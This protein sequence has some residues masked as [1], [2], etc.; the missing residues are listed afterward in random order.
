MLSYQ[1]PFTMREE[2]SQFDSVDDQGERHKPKSLSFLDLSPG[3]KERA[4]A[5]S[6]S[7]KKSLSFGQKHQEQ[8]R[9]AR[10]K[11]SKSS[12]A[13]L[14]D[15][16]EEFRHERRSRRSPNHGVSSRSSSEKL[17]DLQEEFRREQRSKRSPSYK[18]ASKSSTDT[19]PDLQEEFRQPRKPRRSPSHRVS[20]RLSPEPLPESQEVSRQ[21]RKAR[22]SSSNKSSPDLLEV[23]HRR[24]SASVECISSNAVV[25]EAM[26]Y[27][28]E[29]S[30]KLNSPTRSESYTA[31]ESR[32]GERTDRLSRSA[33]L[34]HEHRRPRRSGSKNFR[35]SPTP[36]EWHQ[37]LQQ[38]EDNA[39]L[40]RPGLRRSLKKSQ[41]PKERDSRKS[42]EQG[43]EEEYPRRSLGRKS[44][45]FRKR[46]PTPLESR[47]S[48]YKQEATPLVWHQQFQRSEDQQGERPR[49]RR[50]SKKSE[51][52]RME[53]ATK[54]P[55]TRENQTRDKQQEDQSHPERH[56]RSTSGK[57][58]KSSRTSRD[59]PTPEPRK[60]EDD[61]EDEYSVGR[62][63]SSKSRKGSR[64]SLSHEDEGDCPSSRR[65]LSKKSSRKK[66]PTPLESRK[67]SS[68]EDKEG[69]PSNR[70]SLSKKSSRK[71]S[72]T[73]LKSRRSLSQEDEDHRPRSRR[74]LSKK[75]SRT[76]SPTFFG[77][78][79]HQYELQQDE[80]EDDNEDRPKRSLFRRNSPTFLELRQ[81]QYQEQQEDEENDNSGRRRR[82][83]SKKS[84]SVRKESSHSLSGKKWPLRNLFGNKT[85]QH[86]TDFEVDW[87]ELGFKE[88]S[89]YQN[90]TTKNSSESLKRRKSGSMKR[91]S[92][93]AKLSRNSLS[94]NSLHNHKELEGESSHNATWDRHEEV[95]RVPLK[96]WFT[97]GKLSARRT[98]YHEEDDEH[99]QRSKSL[100]N[101]NYEDVSI[102]QE[103]RPQSLQW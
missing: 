89:Y 97:F 92:S 12:S 16:Q 95:T 52:F 55:E 48:Q 14:P 11:S 42:L 74:S 85:Q 7:V 96:T 83:L 81:H 40:E 59:S 67:S 44:T 39:L 80:G 78:R 93:L 2:I 4:D 23:E 36:L 26:L 50:S 47:E 66:S 20:S 64:K 62:R 28:Q 21:Q 6:R 76:K 17:S 84:I 57:R 35:K 73:P 75:T 91:L 86:S 53:I 90:N 31:L 5:K 72:P 65:S 103:S 3:R 56:I 24:K 70:R 8:Q 30:Q 27:L 87:K 1:Q 13:P 38:Q 45:S 102:D 68:H 63:R 15:L 32:H 29:G 61:L 37:Q 19:Q 9:P 101:L 22:K 49:S 94:R 51:S 18:A 88:C 69:R 43:G 77:S 82:S 33:S 10:R 34:T 41:S 100:K 71:K 46:S 58:T 60:Q 99:S 54:P 98:S 79:Q 25:S